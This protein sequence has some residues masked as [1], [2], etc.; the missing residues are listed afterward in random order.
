[1]KTYRSTDSSQLGPQSA[2]PTAG[3]VSCTGETLLVVDDDPGVRDVVTQIQLLKGY[4][5]LQAW[6]CD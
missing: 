4:T 2:V 1:M 3:K 5:V 6:C